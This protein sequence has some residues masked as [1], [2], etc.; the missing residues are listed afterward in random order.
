MIPRVPGW[1]A[2]VREGEAFPL[3]KKSQFMFLWKKHGSGEFVTLHS[4]G[5]AQSLDQ[6]HTKLER[7]LVSRD[8]C[9]KWAGGSFFPLDIA[10]QVKVDPGRLL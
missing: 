1:D 7:C 8:F 5:I 3:T 4:L 2:V 6:F 9:R 10:N